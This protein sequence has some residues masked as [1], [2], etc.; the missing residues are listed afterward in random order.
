[1]GLRKLSDADVNRIRHRRKKRVRPE[2]PDS[3]RSLAQEYGV[4]ES[5]V[6]TL[7]NPTRRQERRL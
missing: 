3:T 4:S 5:Y 6:Q 7:C 2:D 1:M